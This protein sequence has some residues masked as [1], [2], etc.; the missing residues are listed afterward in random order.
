MSIYARDLREGPH[1]D[2]KPILRDNVPALSLAGY[3]GADMLHFNTGIP[4]YVD[5]VVDRPTLTAAV[6]PPSMEHEPTA[7]RPHQPDQPDLPTFDFKKMATGEPGQQPRLWVVEKDF[8]RIYEGQP[9]PRWP[10]TAS[11][12]RRGTIKREEIASALHRRYDLARAA[13]DFPN[14]PH[15]IEALREAAYILIDFPPIERTKS[16]SNRL[17][18]W[19]KK[20]D[21]S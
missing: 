5:V 7:A 10:M 4:I 13:G 16:I 11:L 19:A 18:D 21:L 12:T 3:N 1:G 20:H 15:G 8:V 2:Q 6:K 17:K 9:L 14:T